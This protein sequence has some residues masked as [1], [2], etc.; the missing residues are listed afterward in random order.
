M[1]EPRL[2][3]R[4]DQSEAIAL[5]GAEAEALI[6]CDGQWVIFPQVVIGFAELGEPPQKS[7]FTNGG[8]FCWVADKPYQVRDDQHTNF[9]PPEVVGG[10]ADRL[11]QLFVRPNA[12]ERYRFVGELDPAWRLQISGMDNCGEAYFRLSPALPS[13]IWIGLGGLHPGDLDHAA[14]DAALNRLCHPINVEERLWVL[15]QLVAYWHGPIH[16]E[17]GFREQE[18][19][20]QSM[21]YPLRWWFRWAGRR[22]KS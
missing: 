4:Y 14:I 16:P 15:R 21:P 13:E 1:G 17:D 22:Q 5:F 8:E 18:L 12:T 19:E 2:Y 10:H 3:E 6:Q 7:H 9:V 20:R 11:I